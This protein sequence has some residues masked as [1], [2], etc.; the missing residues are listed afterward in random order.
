MGRTQWAQVIVSKH[1]MGHAVQRL[2]SK[3]DQS[4]F[5]PMSEFSFPELASQ[6][7]KET[8]ASRERNL[9]R[10]K[11]N[12][13]FNEKGVTIDHIRILGIGLELACNGG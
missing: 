6:K 12:E 1:I 5:R 7:R 13:G 11:K 10:L 2:Q 3:V 4:E 9:K 8:S